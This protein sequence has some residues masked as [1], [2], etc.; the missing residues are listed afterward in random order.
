MVTTESL[1]GRRAFFTRTPVHELVSSGEDGSNG[2]RAGPKRFSKEEMR[3]AGEAQALVPRAPGMGLNRGDSG[4]EADVAFR[5]VA[6]ADIFQ[7]LEGRG[8]RKSAA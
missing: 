8:R 2:P 6:H 4:H 3:Q 5:R 7:T 1:P